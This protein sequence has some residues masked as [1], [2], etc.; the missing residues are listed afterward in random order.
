MRL[1][2]VQPPSFP[3]APTERGLE[4][5]PGVVWQVL[6][7]DEGHWRVGV[8]SP[9]AAR[10]D[11][12]PELERH[13]CPELFHLLSGALTLLLFEPGGVRELPL[14]PGRP[15]LV[16]V[17]HSGFCPGGPHTGTA[18]VVERDRFRTEYATPD[19]WVAPHRE[20]RHESG[21]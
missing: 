15:V 5:R 16:T 19:E 3:E 21:K 13:S 11:E 7:G 14:E 10:A 17:P 2:E 8:Y 9:R 6:A 20:G 18:L 4:I 12:C 1:V